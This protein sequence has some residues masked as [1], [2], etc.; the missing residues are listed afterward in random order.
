M[1]ASPIDAAKESEFG[2]ADRRRQKVEGVATIDLC[3]NNETHTKK[4]RLEEVI[5]FQCFMIWVFFKWLV[6]VLV[7]LRYARYKV[8]TW[9]FCM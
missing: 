6:S 5:K 7:L 9:Y 8:E 3:L 1:F 2:V 4:Q